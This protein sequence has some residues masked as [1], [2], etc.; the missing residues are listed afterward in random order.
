MPRRQR[1]HSYRLHLRNSDQARYLLL[2]HL[3]H[4]RRVTYTM[5][6]LLYTSP[7]YKIK[8]RTRPRTA[9]AS[10]LASKFQSAINAMAVQKSYVKRPVDSSLA[11][12][13]QIGETRHMCL[14]CADYNLCPTCFNDPHATIRL[15]HEHPKYRFSLIHMPDQREWYHY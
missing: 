3:H 7:S 15:K 12:E 11:D 1:Q 14:D 5:K 2:Y 6:A 8:P 4:S 13:P 9:I 10:L